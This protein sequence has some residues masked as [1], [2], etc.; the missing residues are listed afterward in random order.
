MARATIDFGIDLGTTNSEIAHLNGTSAPVIKNLEGIEYTPSAVWLDRGNN[1]VVGRT[2]R[3][4]SFRDPDNAFTEFKLQ[5]GSD[6]VFTFARNKRRVT[7]EELSAE[8]L[9]S[10]RE[11]V[12]NRLGEEFESAVVTV[13]A[14][15]EWPQSDATR[16]AAALA[17]IQQAPL[18]QEP[19]AAALAYGFQ[20][21]DQRAMWLVFDFGGGTFDAAIMSVRDGIIQ[22]VNH[23]GDN[24]LGGKLIDWAIVERVLIPALQ[25][26]YKLSSLGRSNKTWKSLIAKLKIGAEDAKIRLSAAVKTD[27]HLENEKDEAG[28]PIEFDFELTRADVERIALPYFTKAI[29]IAK[30]VLSEKRLG[31]AD[32]SKVILVGGPTQMPVCREALLGS[33]TG[34]SLPLDFHVDP[35][36]VVAQGA[37]I[38]A[39]T[40]RLEVATPRAIRRDQN[41]IELEYKPVGVD[42]EP[43]VAGR[44]I[45]KEGESLSGFTLEFFNLTAQ[46]SWR[47]GKVALG[48][49]GKFLT[50]LWAVK[51][52][53]N[54]FAIE[55]VD[56]R[57]AKCHLVPDSLTYTIGLTISEAPITHNLGVALANNQTIWFFQ[58]GTPLP[59]RKTKTVRTVAEVRKGDARSVARIPIVE[60]DKPYR[61]D[62]NTLVGAVVI[63]G[64]MVKRDLPLNTEIELTLE[65]DASRLIK[66]SAFV[67]LLDEEFSIGLDPTQRLI[68][69]NELD[70]IW[71]RDKA[72]FEQAVREATALG[73]QTAKRVADHIEAVR[74]IQEI[75]VTLKAAAADKDAANKCERLIREVRA[76]CY[77]VT[78]KLQWPKLVQQAEAQITWAEKVVNDHGDADEKATLIA[79][80]QEVRAAIDDE[81]ADALKYRVEQ[82][83]DLTHSV[84]YRQAWWWVEGVDYME[85]HRGLMT[86]QAKASQLLQQARRAVNANDLEGLRAAVRQLA[87]LLPEEK[88]EEIPG[89]RSTVVI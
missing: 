46:P 13:P 32:V 1:L 75:E 69:A 89:Y 11:N 24:N 3:E 44:V 56:A 28:S 12:R 50:S 57:G 61:A 53:P 38:F 7:P 48:P 72:Q 25:R 34:L 19:V 84:L 74:T 47:S 76:A 73:N 20:S 42:S 18:L 60:G 87:N 70:A 85:Q 59:T 49:D 52:A 88:R 43:L 62:L 67:P 55:L 45:P 35:L 80:V 26:Q 10:L 8:V 21:E 31:P 36:T 58:K 71:R 54:Q 23:G 30:R 81:A 5:M 39:G 22:V 68:P 51:G 14:A 64:T 65:I 63:D 79:M 41:A 16:R 2:A 82:L 4:Y 86:D 29:D 40:Q 33:D 66:G 83:S 37:A 15:F 6:A 27:L 77:E 78:D 17:G 9:K